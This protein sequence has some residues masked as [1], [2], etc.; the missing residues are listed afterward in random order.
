MKKNKQ[1]IILDRDGVINQDSDAYIKSPQEWHPIAGSLQAIAR[2]NQAGY[3]VAIATN[4][5]GIAKGFFTEMELTLIHHKMEQALAEEG[6]H[7]DKIVYCPHNP[8]DNCYCR[9]PK[10]GLLLEIARYFNID[11]E[12]ALLVGD[13]KRD[14]Q[15]AQ[16]VHCQAVWVKTGKKMPLS[17]EI[18]SG[19]KIFDDLAAVVENL[20]S[21]SSQF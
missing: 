8:E 9:K 19:V 5:S 17:K 4:Q 13:S 10:P 20:L 3:L 2:L 6:G 15:A 11:L 7:I 1:L 21:G 14:I 16:A 12:H 18:P